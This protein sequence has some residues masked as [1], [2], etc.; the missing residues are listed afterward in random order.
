[1][2]SYFFYSLL[3]HIAGWSSLV[4]RKAHNLEVVGSNPAPATILDGS[5]L[6]LFPNKG[7]NKKLKLMW[8]FPNKGG[9]KKLK[10]M[11]SVVLN[12]IKL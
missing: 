1:M 2:S 10:L 8:L 11:F 12:R 5:A 6:R 9:N 4:A 7:G 3:H